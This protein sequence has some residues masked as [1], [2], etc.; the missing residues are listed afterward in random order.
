MSSIIAF[1]KKE[2]AAITSIVAAII[3]LAVSFGLSLSND[4]VGAITAIASLLAGFITRATVTPTTGVP[5]VTAVK[6]E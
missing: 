2:P 1:F 4:Q 6:D 3:A 5:T